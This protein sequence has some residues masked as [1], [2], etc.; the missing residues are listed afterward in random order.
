VR[1][2]VVLLG[3]EDPGFE[4]EYVPV[5]SAGK[6]NSVGKGVVEYMEVVEVERLHLPLHLQC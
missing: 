5:I 6:V 4:T 2:V 3:K 1:V